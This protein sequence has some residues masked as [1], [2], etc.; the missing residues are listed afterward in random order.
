MEGTCNQCAFPLQRSDLRKYNPGTTCLMHAAFKGHF[1]CV[2]EL[3]GAGADVNI[4]DSNGFEALSYA[5]VGGQLEA[6]TRLGIQT[7]ADVNE[8]IEHEI[9]KTGADAEKEKE[10]KTIESGAHVNETRQIYEILE[11]VNNKSGSGDL[12]Q[13]LRVKLELEI[14]NQCETQNKYKLLEEKQRS[15]DGNIDEEKLQSGILLNDRKGTGMNMS[16]LDVNH[17]TC[18][19]LFLAAGDDVNTSVETEW[20]ALNKFAFT[21]N[22]K[23]VE[24]LVRAG[25]SVNRIVNN[26]F[27]PLLDCVAGTRDDCDFLRQCVEALY[28]PEFH[29]HC[30]T[31]DLLIKA[32]ADV[33]TADV[34]G[35]TGVVFAAAK[36]YNDCVDL[37]IK[38]GAD[39]NAVTKD[40]KTALHHCAKANYP[41]TV[42]KLLRA[43]AKINM[44]NNVCHNALQHT[45]AMGVAVEDGRRHKGVLMTLHAAGEI[46]ASSHVK[47]E[48]FSHPVPEYLLHKDKE[49]KHMCREAIRKQLILLD[50]HQ[51]LFNRISQLQTELPTLMVEYLLYNVSIDDHDDNPEGCSACATDDNNNDVDDVTDCVV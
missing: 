21:G 51:H 6:A 46:L 1:R 38:A 20:L 31:L 26:G 36:G 49:L 24:L 42:I 12:S 41:H 19:R 4:S 47:G 5:A 7:K 35:H 3:L 28:V 29:N 40:G 11:N 44:I 23:C 45:V 16:T 18:L 13:E 37:L 25:A 48:D 33:N 50:P 10:H 27:T 2:R 34:N 14:A 22:Y 30:K 8:A 15:D 32:G 9:L 39:V 17:D 43:G